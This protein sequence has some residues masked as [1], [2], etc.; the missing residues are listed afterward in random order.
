MWPGKHAVERPDKPAYV[1]A[2]SGEVVTYRELDERSN[3]LAHLYREAGLGF[4]DHV[5]VFMENHPRYLE[6][7]WGAQR[8]GIHYTAINSHFNA[9]EVAY[10][11]EDCEAQAVVT[12]YARRDVAAE[13][14]A[15][16]PARVGRRLMIGGTIDGWESY[17]DATAAYPTT[18]IDDELEG[19]SMPYSSGTTGR[20][21][22]IRYNLGRRPIGDPLI[23][24]QGV[25]DAYRLDGDT[26]LLTPAPLYHSAPLQYSMM[27]TRL[28]G[29]VV[30]MEKFDAA[31]ALEAIQKYAI[32]H[33]QFVPTHF[34]RMLKLSDEQRRAYDTSSLLVAIHAAAPCPVEVKQAMIDWWGPILYEYYGATETTGA[35]KIDSHEWLTHKGSVGKPF[36]TPVHIVDE[37]DIEQPIGSPGYVVFEALGGS[38]SAE[39]HNDPAKTKS[40]TTRQG[41]FGTGDIGYVDNDGYLYLTDRKDFMIV[42]GG[43]NIYP[44]EAENVLTMHPAVYDVAVFGVPNDE[45]GEEVKA[46][47]QPVDMDAAGPE[48]E[49]EL[50]EYCRANLAHYKCPRSV[51]FDPELPR[52]DTGK[53]YKRLVRER[54]WGGRQ[55]R[56]V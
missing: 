48:L 25:R 51:D 45:M 56:I 50:I 47:V 35:T 18:P 20:P 1:M 3:R 4:G 10:I 41:W 31:A 54:Y 17:E 15:V 43:V 21:K 9:E 55:T 30:I 46:V 14:L 11:L 38:Y 22:G 52:Q 6:V 13:L 19:M 26:V 5:A 2:G 29:T 39:Y 44:Q 40:N 33:A 36:V 27:I 32:T 37:N 42:S 49:Q 53:L 34:T 12:S 24:M 8:S 16:M 28:G 23:A 7:L